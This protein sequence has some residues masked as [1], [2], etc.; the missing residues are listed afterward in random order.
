MM[1]EKTST[2]EQIPTEA[3][4]E[5]SGFIDQQ[6]TSRAMIDLPTKYDRWEPLA[7]VIATILLAFA[8]LMTAWSG[9]QSARWSGVQSSNFSQA[10]ALRTESSRASTSAGQVMQIDVG[11]FTNWINAYANNNQDLVKFYEDRFRAEFKPAFDA[12]IATNPNKNPDAPSSPFVMPEYKV[13]YAEEAVSLEEQASATFQM[14]Q[15]A[16]ETSDRYVFNTVILA[17]ILFL[18]GLATRINS[19]PM[20]MIVI[21]LGLILLVVGI[22]NIIQLPIQ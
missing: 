2:S 5:E 12:W 10:S 22:Y 19:V 4:I 11:L 6:P 14:G 16:N 20:R 8:T 17:S 9:Y 7:E 1:D 13:S 15:E 21:F 18:S 3:K